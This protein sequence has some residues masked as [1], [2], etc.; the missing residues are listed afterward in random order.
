MS[1]EEV[2]ALIPIGKP[3]TADEIGNVCA[4]LLSDMAS[5]IT[6][7]EIAVDGGYSVGSNIGAG[8]IRKG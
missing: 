7:Q 4:F 8:T 6:G 3:A 5:H 2:Q 1:D